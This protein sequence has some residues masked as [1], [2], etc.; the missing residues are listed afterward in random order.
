M[1]LNLAISGGRG[2]LGRELCKQALLR[3]HRIRILSSRPLSSNALLLKELSEA[4]TANTRALLKKHETRADSIHCVHGDLLKESK[5]A[6]QEFLDSTDI[7]FHL[8]GCVSRRPEQSR[9]MMQLHVEGTRALF[10]A[11]KKQKT[12]KKML[13]LSTSGLVGVSSEASDIATDES[14]YALRKLLNWPYYTSKY[15]QEKLAIALAQELNYKLLI[16]RPTLLLGPGDKDYSSTGEIKSFIERRIPAIPQ[17]GLSF[18]DVRDTAKFALD[19]AENSFSKIKEGEY[20]SYLLGSVN[21]SFSDFMA[22]LSQLSGIASPRLMPS[23]QSQL[24]GARLWDMRANTNNGN[25]SLSAH[26]LQMANSFWYIKAERAIQELGWRPRSP[27][28]T[29]QDT[30]NFIKKNQKQSA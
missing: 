12:I 3:G 23:R 9:Q 11:M 19:A 29:L 28:E 2:F 25:S 17:G 22:K 6:L 30:I 4:E 8:A 15:I 24:W 5:S 26:T 16:L 18:V 7:V 20:R 14:P 27:E 13:L 10:A 1:K 21:M